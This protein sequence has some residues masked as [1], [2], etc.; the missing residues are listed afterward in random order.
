MAKPTPNQVDQIEAGIRQ[1]NLAEVC[2][3]Y[4]LAPQ[5]RWVLFGRA[6]SRSPQQL[7]DIM[8]LTSQDF[9]LDKLPAAL[10]HVVGRP[11]P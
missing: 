1:S 9:V 3:E 2:K 10:F 8:A 11:Y 5:A 7:V 6:V 4:E